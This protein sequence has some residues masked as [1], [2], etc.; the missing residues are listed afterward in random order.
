MRVDTPHD[1]KQLGLEL[2]VPPEPITVGEDVGVTL[3]LSNRGDVP[4][5]VNRRL[6]VGPPGGPASLREVTFEVRG[7]AGY[8][9]RKAVQVNAGRPR[10]SDFAELA[11]GEEVEKAYPLTR[12]ESM[13]VPG[14]YSVRAVYRNVTGTDVWTGSL[15]SDWAAVERV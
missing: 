1:H 14:M 13:H 5:R 8:A 7:P 9:N 3:V 2:R 10:P 11:P 4:I 12:L 15:T 6:L